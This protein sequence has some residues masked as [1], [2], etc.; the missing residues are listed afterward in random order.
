MAEKQ[1]PQKFANIKTDGVV[2]NDGILE[3]NIKQKMYYNKENALRKKFEKE[4]DA[5]NDEKAMTLQ[6][7]TQS[8]NI[9]KVKV[10]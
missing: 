3:S 10:P 6:D 5:K 2:F 4:H 9:Y 1:V 8:R 7:M